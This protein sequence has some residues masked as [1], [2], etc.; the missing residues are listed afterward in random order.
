[1]SCPATALAA[2]HCTKRQLHSLP[3]IVDAAIIFAP[4]G[5]TGIGMEIRPSDMVVR[6]GFHRANAREIAFGLVGAN[7]LVH[8]LDTVIDAVRIPTGVK[9]IPSGAIVGM[10]G[11]KC[12]NDRAP[13]FHVKHRSFDAW[14]DLDYRARHAKL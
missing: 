1:M 11:C 9:R 14:R 2:C 12:L 10:D 5:F 7:A 4:C 8:E 13:L 3:D 6:S